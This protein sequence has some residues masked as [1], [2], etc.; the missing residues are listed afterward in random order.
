MKKIFGF[1]IL[2]SMVFSACA[3][4]AP[5]P[6]EVE[7]WHSLKGA[8]GEVLG[9]LIEEYNNTNQKD[10][11]VVGV[12]QGN[13]QDTQKALM[14]EL[15]AGGS[16]DVAQLEASFSATM[17]AAGALRPMQDFI[18]DADVGVSQD[19]VDAIYP[20]FRSV[21]SFDGDMYTMPFNMSM[22]VLY[23]NATM[24]QDAGVEPPET[25]D[26]F[27]AACTAVTSGDQFGFTINPGNVW[28]VEAL[29]MQ[30]GGLLFNAD[31][32]EVLFNK[33]EAVAGLDLWVETVNQGC[34]KMQPWQDGRTEFFN[35][36]V[37][38][39]KDSSGGISGVKDSIVADFELGVTHL[40]WGKEQ[41]VT[42]GGATVGIFSASPEAEQLA[43]WDFVKYMTSPEAV[44]R[45]SADTGYLPTSALASDLDPLKS[46][47]A[48]DALRA[49]L[50]E[51]LPY[52]RPRP[53]VAGYAEIQSY[54]REA[55][56]AATLSQVS[57]QEALD[58]AAAEAQRVLDKN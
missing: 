18:D 58:T 41:V 44:S 27:L 10:I 22:P 53:S 19:I 21:S 45:L 33:P 25:W 36:R 9:E 17:V 38:F 5:E 46:L 48:E 39:Y 20:G 47:L 31:Y 2:I 55:I 26:D 42:I 13:Y 56:E 12:Y 43:A 51:S 7:F 23:Y 29:M 28:V 49:S 52:L 54:L 16:P 24:L 34:G 50:L 1:L 40:P 57:S 4:A 30:N 37:A 11:T 32:T 3:P 14:A 8:Y 35:G 6:V 15:A